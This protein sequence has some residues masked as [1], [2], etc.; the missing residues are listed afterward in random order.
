MPTGRPEAK[1]IGVG[2]HKTGTSTLGAALQ[3]LGYNRMRGTT[4]GMMAAMRGRFDKA[5]KRLAPFD[6]VGDLPWFMIYQEI[7]KRIPG[8]AFILT[9][10][11]PESWYRSVRAHIGNVRSVHHEWVYGRG[12]G[13]PSEDKD[14]AIAVFANHNREVMAYFRDRPAVLL[15]L[16]FTKGDGWPELCS[17]LSKPVPQAP[18]PHINKSDFNAQR[19]IGKRSKRALKRAKNYLAIKLLKWGG[20]L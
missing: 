7:D 15:V 5:V 19:G 1:I 10:R 11:D 20:H 13:I 17:F 8:C 9:L 14:H 3:V 16:D 6:A 4:H 12:K 18:F 2:F